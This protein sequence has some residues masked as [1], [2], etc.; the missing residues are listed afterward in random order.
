[1]KI[2]I[3]IS[4]SRFT[5]KRLLG[6]LLFL[7]QYVRRFYYR[8]ADAEIRASL[9]YLKRSFHGMLIFLLT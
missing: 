4:K 7:T 1:M 6:I 9:A 5:I 8:S 3:E 2:L